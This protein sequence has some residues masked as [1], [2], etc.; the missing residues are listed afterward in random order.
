MFGKQ[1]S[2]CSNNCYVTKVGCALTPTFNETVTR[3]IISRISDEL[4]AINGNDL[5][6]YENF[7]QKYKN[8]LHENHYLRLSAMHS[9][10]QLYGKINGYIIDKLT[11]DQLDRKIQICKKLLRIFEKLEP[12]LSKQKGK[13]LFQCR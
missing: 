8:T 7:L 1:D 3:F 12:G 5:Q 6:G 4:D 10:F 11:E 13:S 2:C 9:L